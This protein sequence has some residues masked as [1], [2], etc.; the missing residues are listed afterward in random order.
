MARDLRKYSRQTNLRLVIGFLAL[1]FI[2]G[3]GLIYLLWGRESA[4]VGVI[5]V[6]GALIPAGLVWLVLGML[7]W[8]ARKAR[9]E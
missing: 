4:L 3:I 5:C 9:D 7:G 2:V 6:L 8:V 1:V